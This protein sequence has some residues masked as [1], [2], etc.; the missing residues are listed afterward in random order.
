LTHVVCCK[1]RHSY[2]YFT[3]STMNLVNFF[4]SSI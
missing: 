2:Y 1:S 4:S 3:K